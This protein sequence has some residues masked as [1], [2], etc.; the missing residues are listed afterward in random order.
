MMCV[1]TSKS[2]ASAPGELLLQPIV[3]VHSGD[4]PPSTHI[5][6]GERDTTTMRECSLTVN[7]SLAVH[8]SA[9]LPASGHNLKEGRWAKTDL[10][11]GGLCATAHQGLLRI[12]GHVCVSTWGLWRV[13]NRHL[14]LWTRSALIIRIRQWLHNWRVNLI[15]SQYLWSLNTL[16]DETWDTTDQMWIFSFFFFPKMLQSVTLIPVCCSSRDFT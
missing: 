13:G 7:I 15:S 14:Y 9:A 6:S 1:Y 10:V 2:L 12:T 8:L 4:Q 3:Y 11:R 16:C 5:N